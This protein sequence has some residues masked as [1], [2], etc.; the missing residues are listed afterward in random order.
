MQK[1]DR[2]TGKTINILIDCGA[3]NNYIDSKCKIGYSVKLETPNKVKKLYGY[4]YVKS[5]KSIHLFNYELT[6]FEINSLTGSN[7]ILGIQ[8][9]REIG[10]TIDLVNNEMK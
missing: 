6:F 8:G 7:I 4:S 3:T 5:K 1:T 2:K 9:L 10:A